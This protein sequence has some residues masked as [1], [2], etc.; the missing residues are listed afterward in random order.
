MVQFPRVPQAAV[1]TMFLSFC[2]RAW[3]WDRRKVKST[4]EPW[5]RAEVKPVRKSYFLRLFLVIHLVDTWVSLFN[6]LLFL[7]CFLILLMSRVF[8]PIWPL[9]ANINEAYRFSVETGHGC[10]LWQLQISQVSLRGSDAE[11]GR[12][13]WPSKQQV[14]RDDNS[15]ISEFLQTVQRNCRCN[16]DCVKTDSLF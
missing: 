3:V 8:F 16:W 2:F 7:T 14:H 1:R 6:S 10:E 4:T 12:S 9:L 13:L 11:G 5:S 15:T